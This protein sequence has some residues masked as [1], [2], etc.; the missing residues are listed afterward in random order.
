ELVERPLPQRKSL[1][2]STGVWRV[3]APP[4]YPFTASLEQ[5]FASYS[6]KGVIVCLPPEPDERHVALLLEGARLVLAER[7]VT[8]FILVQHGG[9][10]A[11]FARTLYLEAP[12]ITTCVV[13]VPLDHPQAIEWV[14]A[15]GKAAVGYSEA[16]YD[17]FGRRRE[18]VLRLLPP[19]QEA[20]E[21]PLGPD[22]VLLI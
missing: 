17:T 20:T 2:P 5:A 3:I 9:G 10:G 13:D 18:P 14:L 4:D 19:S 6:G 22:D 21:S 12:R 11:A 15:E 16:I 7:E 8:H 1:V